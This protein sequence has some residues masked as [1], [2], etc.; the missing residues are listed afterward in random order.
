MKRNGRRRVA[1]LLQAGLD[2]RDRHTAG[3]VSTHGL[4]VARGHLESQ[5]TDLIFPP[6]TNEANEHLA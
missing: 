5:L 2:L 1:E 6:N 3:K 4:G